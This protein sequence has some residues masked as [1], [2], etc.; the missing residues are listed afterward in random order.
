VG[1]RV[2]YFR[3]EKRNVQRIALRLFRRPLETWEYAGLA[4]ASEETEV[5]V[6]T[7]NAGLY[8]EV[9]Q[10]LACCYHAVQRIRQA[11]DGPVVVIDAFRI[12]ASLRRRGLGSAIF[13]R[14]IAAASALGARRIETLA[15]RHGDENGYYTWPRLGFDGPLPDSVRRELPLG[16]DHA[17]NVLDLMRGKKGR[18]W[19][20]AHGVPLPL[21][22][23]LAPRSRSRAVFERYLGRLPPNRTAREPWPPPTHVSFSR[24]PQACA[25]PPAGATCPRA[26]PACG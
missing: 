14:Q 22:F 26:P 5:E 1:A 8:V 12:R 24:K 11:E 18:R 2:R 7:L 16:L 6:G 9:F 25:G 17:T 19:W 23:D 15:G 13:A 10:P 3:G 4:G 20:K 21:A